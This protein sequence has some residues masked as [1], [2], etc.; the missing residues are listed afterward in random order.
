VKIVIGCDHGGLELKNRIIKTLSEFEFED[1]GTFS[2]DSVDYPDYANLV[3]TKIVARE[4]QFGV[5]ICGSGQGMAMRANRTKGIRAALVWN[6]EVTRLSR[7]HNNANIICLGGRILPHGIAVDL[8]KTFVKTPFAEGR[9]I[10]R[11][12]KLDA[13]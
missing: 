3:C 7:E 8:V 5:L 1:V 4:A 6:Q 10:A 12:A 2:T 11:V 13:P 9:H